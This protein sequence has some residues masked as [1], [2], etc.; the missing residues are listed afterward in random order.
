VLMSENVCGGVLGSDT[1]S[2]ASVPGEGW[3]IT[4]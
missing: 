4:V 3:D 2:L 1:P